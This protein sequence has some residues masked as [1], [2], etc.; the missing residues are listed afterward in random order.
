MREI[1][2]AH[3]AEDEGEPDAEEEQQG[4]LRQRIDALIEK[5]CERAHGLPVGARMP[6]Y[7]GWL[8]D[9]PSP[10]P[11]ARSGASAHARRGSQ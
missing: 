5:E 3:D 2:D 4:G 7:V 9:R 1:D 10:E 8:A 11:T 6:G